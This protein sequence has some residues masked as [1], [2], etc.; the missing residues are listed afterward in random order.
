MVLLVIVLA[1][2]LL[3]IL[4]QS[5]LF[6]RRGGGDLTIASNNAKNIASSL[7]LF[8]QEFGSYPDEHTREALLEQ[9]HENVP[10][11]DHANAYLAQ[12]I[13]NGMLDSETSFY[14]PGMKGVDKGDEILKPGEL[15]AAGENGF[16]YLMTE[17]GKALGSN[18]SLMPL[19][20][21]PIIRGGDDPRFD[22]E[23]LSGKYVYGMANGSSK[24]G[25]I[26]EGGIALSKGRA[27]LFEGGPDSLFGFDTPV[28]KMPLI[29]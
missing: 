5:F 24:Q 8:R 9:G 12:L 21:T 3:G 15:L 13:V 14:V 22:P 29:D 11:G 19:V 2:V 16:A 18:K 25:D 7:N 1:V 6:G 17:E 4:S 26:G 27:H 10:E 23:P 28:I 20:I